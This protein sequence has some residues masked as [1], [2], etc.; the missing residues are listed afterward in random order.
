MAGMAGSV[1]SEDVMARLLCQLL[2]ES[3][4]HFSKTRGA[5]GIGTPT[6]I[7]AFNA[8]AV[9]LLIIRVCD[10]P[11]SEYSIEGT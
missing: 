5:L 7:G 9:H 2:Q 4:F 3:S 1:Y 11:I 8:R 6:W 10:M